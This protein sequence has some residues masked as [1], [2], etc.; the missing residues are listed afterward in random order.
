MV[1]KPTPVRIEE[2]FIYIHL[3]I[4]KSYT[5]ID[6]HTYMHADTHSKD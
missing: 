5:N 6:F 2:V 3:L 1:V 4:C